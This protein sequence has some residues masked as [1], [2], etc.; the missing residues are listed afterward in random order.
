MTSGL[1]VAASGLAPAALMNVV[2]PG[3]RRTVDTARLGVEG[4]DVLLEAPAWRVDGATYLLPAFSALSGAALGVRLELAARCNGA[5]TPWT[6]GITLGDARFA[7][8]PAAP[9]LEVDVDVFRAAA[10]VEAVRLRARVRAPRAALAGTPWM[11]SLSASTPLH[12][13]SFAAA[14]PAERLAVPPLSQ[15]E[16]DPELARRICSPTCVAMVLDY[17]GRPASPL[18]LAAEMFHAATDLYGV[19]P[20]AI[21]AAGRH[22][23]AGY[24]LR[25]PDWAAAAW[26]LEQRM[27]VIVSVRYAAGELSDAAI[28]ATPGHLLVLTGL[29]GETALVNDPAAAGAGEVARRY[30]AAELARV[31]L[32]RTGVGYVL[33]PFPAG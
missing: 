4:E 22:G 32:E 14:P 2:P 11:L 13:P 8:L 31:W 9:P 5:W 33:F 16:T 7:P 1:W 12:A 17:W 10:P 24:L 15:M 29:D 19:W 25:F 28:A 20:A 27:P 23:V 18:A 26:C 6:A 30:R 21:L 3:C